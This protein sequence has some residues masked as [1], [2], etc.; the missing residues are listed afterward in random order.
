MTITPPPDTDEYSPAFT[1]YV[2]H[3]TRNENVLGVLAEQLEQVPEM[4]RSFGEARGDYR[5]APGKWSVKEV[6]GH[7]S[8]SERIFAYRALR[9]ARGDETPLAGFD[10]QLYA[11]EMHAEGR[12]LADMVDEWR[13]VRRATLSL[14]RGLPAAAWTRRGTAN[15]HTMSTRAA[16]WVVAGHTRHHAAV[17]RDRYTG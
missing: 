6:I 4:A 7:L 1:G 13:D 14:F 16:A 5:Y 9:I 2:G 12:T 3:L 11:P 8:D 10:E 17:L 15:G